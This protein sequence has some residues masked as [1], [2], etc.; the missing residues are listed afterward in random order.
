VHLPA[1]EQASQ[2]V[3]VEQATQVDPLVMLGMY[4]FEKAVHTVS[5]AQVLQ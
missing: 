3:I 1:L 4:E 5:L 2:L